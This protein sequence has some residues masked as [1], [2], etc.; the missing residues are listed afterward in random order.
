MGARRIFVAGMDG[1]LGPGT[2]GKALY[3]N[4]KDEKTDKQ[5]IIE[6]HMWCQKFLEEIEA[7]LQKNGREGI[8]IITPTTYKAF[9]K[10][11][12]NYI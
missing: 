11:V 1:Y 3:Y 7:Y 8:H 2:E 4:E 9:Y 12:E 5:M 6:R 10:S